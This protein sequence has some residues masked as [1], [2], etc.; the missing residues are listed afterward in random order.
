MI[1]FRFL[2]DPLCGSVPYVSCVAVD[3]GK[4][5]LCG[6]AFGR[7]HEVATDVDGFADDWSLRG[8]EPSVQV[9]GLLSY[10][11]KRHYLSSQSRG[12]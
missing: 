10:I 2:R 9:A 3:V 12:P 4:L 6:A 5:L 8:L 11:S 7:V 1:C